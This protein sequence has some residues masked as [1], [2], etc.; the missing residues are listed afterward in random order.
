MTDWRM[1]M[2]AGTSPAQYPHYP[3]NSLNGT[4]SEDSEDIEGQ[5][6]KGTDAHTMSGETDS[7]L[8]VP[9]PR[10]QAEWRSAWRELATL[11]AG[12]SDPADPVF[13]HVMR[14]L[15]ACSRAFESGNAEAFREAAEGVKRLC[16]R[17][18]PAGDTIRR[19]DVVS[20][21]RSDG[22]HPRGF[23]NHVL[24]DPD[25]TTWA[26]VSRGSS[27]SVVS[28]KLLRPVT[29]QGALHGKVPR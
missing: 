5:R 14:A 18:R 25:G 23:I 29:P 16:E 22:T 4:D 1:L 7:D 24:A 12:F 28:M 6:G 15:D 11:S 3:Q 21:T 19:G 17:R 9:T 8:T 27:W 20:W 2:N 10:T 13:G 26:L